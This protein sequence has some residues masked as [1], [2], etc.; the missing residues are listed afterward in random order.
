MGYEVTGSGYFTITKAN[1]ERAQTDP[2]VLAFIRSSSKIEDKLTYLL[3]EHGFNASGPD[4]NGDREVEY[5]EGR[6]RDQESLLK[7]LA[8]FLEGSMDFQGEDGEQWTIEIK[9]V[10]HE[11][12]N[13]HADNENALGEYQTLVT[14]LFNSGSSEVM[15]WIIKRGLESKNRVIKNHIRELMDAS[16]KPK[17]GG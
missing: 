17:T 1:H 16:S 11:S 10:V 7:T 8:S 3:E 4:S 12:Y 14:A 13:P 2:N 6:W 15:D 5:F 9:G